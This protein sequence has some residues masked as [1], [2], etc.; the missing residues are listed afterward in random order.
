MCSPHA[1]WPCQPQS[2]TSGGCPGATPCGA[3]CT[4]FPH[5]LALLCFSPQD[6]PKDQIIPHTQHHVVLLGC[7]EAVGLLSPGSL[8][9]VFLPAY[10]GH[11]S[12]SKEASRS[13]PALVTQPSAVC[14]WAVCGI[15]PCN[16]GWQYTHVQA[17]PSN[18]KEHLWPH[19]LEIVQ[20]QACPM[21]YTFSPG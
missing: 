10:C 20:H 8:Q 6:S 13:E 21:P 18:P 14:L 1:L 19:V 17:L 11:P 5:L 16:L 15:M 9:P 7:R 2:C 4:T 3:S 12:F